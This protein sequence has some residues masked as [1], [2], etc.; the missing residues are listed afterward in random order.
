MP[1]LDP[2]T[3]QGQTMR[4]DWAI[5]VLASLVVGVVVYALILAP[6]V[7]WRRR[8]DELPPQ[9]SVNRRVEMFS[10]AIPL[11]LIGFLF[12]VTYTSEVSVDA[13]AA[14]P[15]ATVDVTGFRWSWR[16][17]YP[18]AGIQILGTPGQPPELVLAQNETTQIDL[19]TDDVN[20]SFWVSDFLFKRDAVPG[21]VNRFDLTPIR[22]G[23]FRGACTQFCGLEHT[24]MTFTV[25][26]VPIETYRRWTASHGKARV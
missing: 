8:S 26:V 24:L 14:H 15:F 17:D 1:L 7:L 19:R 10:V 5:F 12:Y 11:A 9:F 3:V 23:I 18:D 22:T 16:F 21:I 20:H 4:G 2:A 13:V 6:L 25:R